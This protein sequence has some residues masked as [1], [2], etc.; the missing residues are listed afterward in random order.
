[1]NKLEF[2]KIQGNGNDEIAST[3]HELVLA[4]N[5]NFNLIKQ[6]IED[7]NGR[8]FYDFPITSMAELDNLRSGSYRILLTKVG[9][10]ELFY[11]FCT[12]DPDGRTIRQTRISDCI[13]IR[14]FSGNKWEKWISYQETFLKSVFGDNKGYGITQKF[15]TE[16]IEGKTLYTNLG[17]VDD[18]YS[19]GFAEVIKAGYYTY[20]KGYNEGEVVN[21]ILIV[22]NVS[23]PGA[24]SLTQLKQ[25][26]GK[27]YIRAFDIDERVWLEW[28]DIQKTFFQ[29]ELGDGTDCGLT[30]KFL[31]EILGSE[32]NSES[33]DGSVWGKLKSIVDD[34]FN[35]SKEVS[36]LETDS[37]RRD[38]VR[39]D[40]IVNDASI[41]IEGITNAEGGEVLFVASKRKFAYFLN[42]RYYSYWSGF[43]DYQDSGKVHTDK[44]YLCANKA[45]V[46][47]NGALLST[48]YEALGIAITANANAGS[49]LSKI[50]E[51]STVGNVMLDQLDMLTDPL[52]AVSTYSVFYQGQKIGVLHCFTNA[53]ADIITQCFEANWDIDVAGNLLPDYNVTELRSLIRIYNISSV[54][55][56]NEIPLR[57]WGRWKYNQKVI[58]LSG[59][60]I[61]E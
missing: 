58:T 52:S 49:A 22:S 34:V 20:Q 51:I 35:I 33:E 60:V 1:M 43:N 53:R 26:L 16:Q 12:I 17:I 41:V 25:E 30:Q 11:L 14:T 6:V 48:D 47:H 39:F 56:A 29:S 13:Y 55:I 57:T 28:Q 5:G 24:T 8:L 19:D 31:S 10:T 38:T 45:Y 36:T 15:F 40:G 3:G 54:D 50:E 9:I 27:T 21:G 18:T 44:V 59:G 42:N 46:Y 61:I 4:F 23:Y 2:D 7:L 32:T 37:E